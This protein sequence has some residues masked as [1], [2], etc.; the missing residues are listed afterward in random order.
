M[1]VTSA[2]PAMKPL[3][4]I[5]THFRHHLEHAIRKKPLLRSG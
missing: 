4:S 3:T 2:A 5:T 1:E